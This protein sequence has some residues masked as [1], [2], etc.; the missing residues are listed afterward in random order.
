MSTYATARRSRN[1]LLLCRLLPP[2]QFGLFSYLIFF[3]TE[4]IVLYLLGNCDPVE[5]LVGL[6]IQ[7]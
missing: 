7:F 6:Q 2:P 4:Q 1:R 5:L 3:D